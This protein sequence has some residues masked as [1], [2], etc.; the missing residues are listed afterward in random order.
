MFY[1]RTGKIEKLSIEMKRDNRKPFE[2]EAN[3]T[4]ASMDEEDLEI[5]ESN[6]SVHDLISP[7]SFNHK[8]STFFH[9]SA[10]KKD[11]IYKIEGAVKKTIRT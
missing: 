1:P 3:P 9:H 8:K 2:T 4:I 10:S 6:R 11:L 7:D 5:P